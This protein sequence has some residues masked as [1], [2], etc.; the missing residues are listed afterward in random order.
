MK[1]WND[2]EESRKFRKGR[3]TVSWLRGTIDSTLNSC[4]IL[5]KN[6]SMVNLVVEWWRRIQSWTFLS[7]QV[8]LIIPPTDKIFHCSI[9]P[10][11]REQGNP[12]S[13]APKF[14]FL[15]HRDKWQSRDPESQEQGIHCLTQAKNLWDLSCCCFWFVFLGIFVVVVVF[16]LWLFI[17]IIIYS[18]VNQEGWLRYFSGQKL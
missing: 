15:G 14:S 10:Y 11:A 16:V 7:L 13:T 9:Q 17:T 12:I 6:S 5:G 3:G 4:N 8:C 18:L 1:V 2:L